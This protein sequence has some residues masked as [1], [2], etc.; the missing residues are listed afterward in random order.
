MAIEG[1]L[2]KKLG[3]LQRFDEA[4]VVQGVT[5][6]EAG[7]CMVTQVKTADTDG[8]DAVQ[9]GFG[10][11]KDAKLNRPM[12]GHLKKSGGQFKY[13][14]EFAV[15]DV[16]AWKV[17]QRVD[18][19]LFSP[20][21][22]VD[23]T[24]ISKGRGFQGGVKR[25]GFSGGPKTHGQSDR[26]RAPG[27]IGSTTTPGRVLKGLRM[28]GHMGDRQVTVR[29][30]LVVESNPARGILFLKGAVPGGNNGLVKI[31]RAKGAR[32]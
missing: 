11:I 15:D 25:H 28:A 24:A 18:V 20:G 30:L 13:L 23:V 26:H 14:R 12:K 2:G 16:E 29:N 27:S 9:L 1:L 7:P 5:V 31:R 22:R 6:V 4:G 32:G 21:D 19:T 3:M 10:A 8:Y 17:G